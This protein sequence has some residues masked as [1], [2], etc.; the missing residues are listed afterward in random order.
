MSTNERPGVYTSYEISGSLYG[1]RRGSAVGLAA[2]ADGGET[3]KVVELTGWAQA[4]EVFGGGNLVKLAEILF[5]NG[6][7]KV[8]AV[9]AEGV[10]YTPAFK[11]LMDYSDIRFMVCDH[12]TFWPEL[13]FMWGLPAV[14]QG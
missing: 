14:F 4:Q 10:A 3:G 6:A 9:K 1:G 2:S 8:Y 5:R 13:S 11:A 12:L 7:P